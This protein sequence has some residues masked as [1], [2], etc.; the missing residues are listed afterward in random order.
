MPSI[1]LV[2]TDQALPNAAALDGARELLFGAF[3]GAHKEDKRAWRM[4]WKRLMR[5]HPGEMLEFLVRFQRS[6]PFHR[7]HMAIEQQVFNA[8]DRFEHFDVLRDWLKIGSGWVI[9]CAGPKG[10]VVPVPKSISY[11]KADESEFRQFHDQMID[12][13]RGDH[14]AHYL[15]PHLESDKAFGMIDAILLGFGE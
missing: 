7:R 10:G 8:Q 6:G 1:T 3:D 15:W 4:F 9:W 5:L 12:F 13:L 2:R 11:A 14:A